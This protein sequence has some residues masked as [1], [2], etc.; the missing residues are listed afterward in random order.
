MLSP[1]GVAAP[2][3]IAVS[4]YFAITYSRSLVW[5]SGCTTRGEPLRCWGADGGQTLT[6]VYS[7]ECKA[8]QKAERSTGMLPILV[9]LF[10]FSYIIL[11]LLVVEQ[12]R[13]IE[14][15]RALIREMLQDSNQLAALKGK[16][17]RDESLR[18]HQKSPTA[19]EPSA[20]SDPQKAPAG[21][22][23]APGG[24]KSTGKSEHPMKEAPGRPASDLEDVRRSTRII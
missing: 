17:A 15:Q 5:I 20:P 3:V 2:G 6:V 21:A 16:I 9:V 23:K 24:N 1:G 11:T 7:A 8:I 13:T 19:A 14:T 22:P 4:S 18:Q 12:G 10:V